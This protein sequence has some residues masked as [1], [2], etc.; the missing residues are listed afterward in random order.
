MRASD[1]RALFESKAYSDWIKARE[2]RAKLQGAIL[3]RID[4]VI[5]AIG[6]LAKSLTRRF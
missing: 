4:N 1:V 2:N 6:N 3:D 5:K